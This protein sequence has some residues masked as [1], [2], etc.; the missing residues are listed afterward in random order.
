LNNYLGISITLDE[1]EIALG[2]MKNSKNP[3]EITLI[4]SHTIMPQRSSH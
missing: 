4:Q 1:S 3:G 2:R